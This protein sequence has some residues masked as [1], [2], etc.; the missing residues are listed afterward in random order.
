MKKN[1]PKI[2]REKRKKIH[3]AQPARLEQGD[4]KKVEKKK[5]KTT[6]NVEE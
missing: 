6:K 4:F 2:P 3:L 5:P 1:I